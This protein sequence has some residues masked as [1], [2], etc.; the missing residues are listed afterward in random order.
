MLDEVQN[1]I[2]LFYKMKTKLEM[3]L[4][5]KNPDLAIILV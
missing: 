3:H 5:Q 4:K 1:A 2:N